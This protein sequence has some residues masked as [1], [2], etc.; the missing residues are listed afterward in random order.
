MGSQHETCATS[1]GPV[2][3]PPFANDSRVGVAVTATGGAL[4]R[5]A[6]W[7]RAIEISQRKDKPDGWIPSI[8]KLPWTSEVTVRR[9]PGARS[10]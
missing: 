7:Q 5:P 10:L 4:A 1:N 8:G 2:G 6:V 9:M 3:A